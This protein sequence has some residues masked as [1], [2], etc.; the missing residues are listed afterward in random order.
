[1]IV[2]LHILAFRQSDS[3]A[4]SDFFNLLRFETFP[5]KT[6]HCFS[7]VHLVN[8]CTGADW[9]ITMSSAN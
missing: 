9:F 8:F 1:M 5:C 6:G 7:H 2:L 4:K 3:K